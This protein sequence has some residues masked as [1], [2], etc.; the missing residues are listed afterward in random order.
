MWSG[1][2]KVHIL[3]VDRRHRSE[4]KACARFQ[5]LLMTSS[6]PWKPDQSL[7][8]KF[9]VVSYTYGRQFWTA[10]GPRVLFHAFP[11]LVTPPRLDLAF[12][13]GHWRALRAHARMLPPF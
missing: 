5:C 7:T 3:G 10:F 9:L 8:D 13:V 12:H 2:L 6:M 11:D 1:A 4:R